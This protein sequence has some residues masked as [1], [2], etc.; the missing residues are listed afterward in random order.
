MFFVCNTF[1]LVVKI[2]SGS[3]FFFFREVCKN[4]YVIPLGPEL[5]EL[6]ANEEMCH[7]LRSLNT[8]SIQPQMKM[9]DIS[10]V[11]IKF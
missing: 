4:E 7:S 6:Y 9:T 1:F 5:K 2:M 8:L 11:H 10:W 3:F